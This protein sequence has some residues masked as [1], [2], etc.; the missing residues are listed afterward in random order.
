MKSYC[1]TSFSIYLRS[2]SNG[3]TNT[4]SFACSEEVVCTL[5]SSEDMSNIVKGSSAFRIVH[6]HQYTLLLV[7]K[8]PTSL[9]SNEA[10]DRRRV[11]SN[12]EGKIRPIDLL[13]NAG[14]SNVRKK[15]KKEMTSLG[16]EPR[17]PGGGINL[18]S[19]TTWFLK[20]VC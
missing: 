6:Y 2:T 11:K 1:R 4:H 18:L 17:N 19:Q 20:P 8:W 7:W 9:S 5:I 14:P 15:V 3:I 12:I 10:E 13:R 16:F